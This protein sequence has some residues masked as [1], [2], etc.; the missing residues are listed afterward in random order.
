MT[1]KITIPAKSEVPRECKPGQF[2]QTRVFGIFC[3]YSSWWDWQRS[4]RDNNCYWLG[5]RTRMQSIPQTQV[6]GKRRSASLP[7][8]TRSDPWA[9]P[10][11]ITIQRNLFLLFN[12]GII[13]FL[14]KHNWPTT[15]HR[16]IFWQWN[17]KSP[18]FLVLFFISLDESR[19]SLLAT[20]IAQTK[21]KKCNATNVI[22]YKRI[23][24]LEYLIQ[25]RTSDW[26]PPFLIWNELFRLAE[27]KRAQVS[28]TFGEKR[29]M[30]PSL[31]PS[32]VIPRQKKRIRTTYGKRAVM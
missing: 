17:W 20:P 15:N 29:W 6:Q 31:M 10:T 21:W 12:Q 2:F 11:E 32:S 14:S 16:P 25:R 18:Y 26:L 7:L 27:K 1:A 28:I 9:S 4:H 24:T 30:I 22:F 8:T 5:Y 19:L 23:W 3:T 13:P